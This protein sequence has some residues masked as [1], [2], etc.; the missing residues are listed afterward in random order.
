MPGRQRSRRRKAYKP[1]EHDIQVAAFAWWAL[2]ANAHKIPEHLLFAVP[3]A[4]KMSYRA[5]AWMKAEGRRAGV[6]DVFLM[7][8][9]GGFHGLIFE[10]KRPGEKPTPEQEAF[11]FSVRRHGYNALVVHSTEEFIRAVK[12]YLAQPKRPASVGNLTGPC[13]PPTIAPP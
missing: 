8:P 10:F 9:A 7:I 13:Q 3:N 12:A 5:A 4:A 1:L 11:L 2:Y 6:S